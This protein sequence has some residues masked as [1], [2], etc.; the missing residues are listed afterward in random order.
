MDSTPITATRFFRQDS[1]PSS[2]PDGATWLTNS[3]GSG[4]DTTASYVFN[5]ASDTWELESAVGPSEPTDGTPVAGATWRDTSTGTPKQYDG[6]AYIAIRRSLTDIAPFEDTGTLLTVFAKQNAT[7]P[8]FESDPDDF[9]MPTD[10]DLEAAQTDNKRLIP[11]N[12]AD[13]TAF[14]KYTGSFDAEN[15]VIE[16]NGQTLLNGTA[17]AGERFEWKESD[18]TEPHSVHIESNG[19]RDFTYDAGSEIASMDK[20]PGQFASRTL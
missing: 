12:T 19:D 9:D 7:V 17:T 3:D 15:I 1:K 14:I 16:I 10:T 20:Q 8:Y 5:A 4:D 18:Y 6:T 2:A 13:Y 11:E